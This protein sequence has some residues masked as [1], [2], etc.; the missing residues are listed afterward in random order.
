MKAPA[1]SIAGVMTASAIAFMLTHAA[2]ARA[3]ETEPV[4][5]STCAEVTAV[6]PVIQQPD[7]VTESVAGGEA[8]PLSRTPERVVIDLPD[9]RQKP[10]SG[11][12]ALLPD[13]P[14]DAVP[15]GAM[16]DDAARE[17][18]VPPAL[19]R[20]MVTTESNFNPQAVSP[21][22][23]VGLMQLMPATARRFGA[24]DPAD[25][26]TN[27]RTGTRYLRWLLDRFGSDL[28]LAVAAY[29]AGEG[30]VDKYGGQIPPYAETRNYVTKVLDRYRM[31]SR[32]SEEVLPAVVNT[33]QPLL[34][35]S[36]GPARRA[37]AERALQGVSR[38][39]QAV[40]F[41]NSASWGRAREI[42]LVERAP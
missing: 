14:S 7:S 6:R 35:T 5:C 21:K 38:L 3:D 8:I 31:Y 36:S 18:N 22:G 34:K 37:N 4:P 33:A 1:K 20:A 11:E 41:S 42:T 12:P 23:A 15:Y 17:Y 39:M 26:R 30:A 25:P 16:I 2:L 10:A 29:N 28:E 27:L 32:G 13:F 9:S 24:V 40:L 19:V